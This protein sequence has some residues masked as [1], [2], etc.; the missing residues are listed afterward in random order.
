MFVMGVCYFHEKTKTCVKKQWKQALFGGS[1]T[2]LSNF[3]KQKSSYIYDVMVD[4]QCVLKGWGHYLYND[5][6]Q[7]KSWDL[8]LCTKRLIV[9]NN[10]FS[11]IFP[12]KLL[13]CQMFF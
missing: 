5:I 7:N 1:E 13:F 6:G 2:A 4:Y 8:V 9:Q 10:L 3:R 11:G 12:K